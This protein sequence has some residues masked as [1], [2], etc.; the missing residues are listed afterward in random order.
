MCQG[1]SKSDSDCQIVS[2]NV[3]NQVREFQGVSNSIRKC[4]EVS[5]KC[6]DERQGVSGAK[7]QGGAR[8]VTSGH[9]NQWTPGQQAVNGV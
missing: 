3:R 9:L 5:L 1:Q 6:V 4:P 2:G 8:D 7:C